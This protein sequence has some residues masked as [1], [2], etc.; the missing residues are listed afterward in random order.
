MPNKNPLAQLDANEL[1]E[2]EQAADALRDWLVDKGFPRSTERFIKSHAP[3]RITH[4]N[5]QRLIRVLRMALD[6]GYLTRRNDILDVPVF[7]IGDLPEDA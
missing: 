2:L 7:E 4:A 6:R 5:D 3:L 1:Q